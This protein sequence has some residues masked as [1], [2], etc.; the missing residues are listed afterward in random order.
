MEPRDRFA[1]ALDVD[2]LVVA[3]R[4]ADELK[5]WFGVAKIGLELWAAA[6]PD[7][8]V[9]LVDRGYRV[10]LDVK[11]HDIPTTVGRAAKVLGALGPSYVTIHAAGGVDML[12]AG[13]EG[14]AEGA[15]GAGL[16]AP[17]ALGVT[18]LTSDSDV[19]PETL[20]QRVEWSAKA[21]CAGFVCAAGEVARAKSVAPD[22][23][24]VVPG[25]RTG[26]SPTH[27]QA[28]P[29]TPQEAFDAGA[30]LIV[31]GRTVTAASDRAAAAAALVGAL[32]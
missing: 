16:T 29:A 5:P 17:G 11:M 24:A 28:R 1:L 32:A 21:G 18:I 10:F 15:R 30:D 7:A 8:V 13:V 9:S 12:H 4:W 22:L 2:D 14:L 3:T 23:L 19:L 27:D 25:I 26:G 31:V 6:G 20:T